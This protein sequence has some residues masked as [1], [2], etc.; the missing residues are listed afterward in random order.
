MD[1]DPQPAS[2]PVHPTDPPTAR[3]FQYSLR[4]L[5]GLMT[6]LSVLLA[7]VYTTP[8]W[9]GIIVVDY[10]SVLT[11]VVLATIAIYGR[12]YQ[13]T[14]AIG[15]L[16]PAGVA[17]WSCGWLLVSWAPD[18]TGVGVTF[19]WSPNEDGLFQWRLSVLCFAGL[20]L[21]SG[22]LAMVVRWLVEP[23]HQR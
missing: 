2:D 4:S 12:G 1:A 21:L 7:A 17:A 8:P 11:A 5:L 10:F 18:F 6:L 13:R 23:H 20:V 19:D 9:L 15:T 3:P 22:L 14:F 16:I